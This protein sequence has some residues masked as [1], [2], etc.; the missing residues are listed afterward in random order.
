MSSNGD[1]ETSVRLPASWVNTH[2]AVA[3]RDARPP[4]S[5]L[6]ALESIRLKSTVLVTDYILS[7]LEAN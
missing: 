6:D 5:I 7:R 3:D 2:I 1:N 4:A